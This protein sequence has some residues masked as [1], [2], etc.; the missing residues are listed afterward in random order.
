MQVAGIDLAWGNRARTGIAVTDEQGSLLR[1]G[2]VL[3][4]DDIAEFLAGSSLAAIAI[5]APIIVTNATGM[6][7]CERELSRDFRQFH[8]GTHPTNLGRPSMQ[9]HPRAMRLVEQHGWAT[10]PAGEASPASPVALEVYPHSSMV[11][12]FG[13][14]RILEYKAKSGRTLPMRKGQ[15]DVLMRLME[16]HCETPL[17]LTRNS[18][19][20]ELRVIAASA[21]RQSD[22]NLIEDEIDAIFCAYVAWV[23][24]TS[25]LEL[26]SYGDPTT[27]VIV[28]FPPP[29]PA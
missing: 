23:F 27:G 28:T 21:Q 17:A 29:G 2:S 15:F 12:L 1:S 4:D 3:T 18:R 8:A 10:I 14:S 9:P 22:L 5:D 13:L 25:P 24:A 6:R 11:G 26:A 7:E 16:R 20:L 19:W